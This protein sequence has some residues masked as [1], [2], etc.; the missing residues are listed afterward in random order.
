MPSKTQT[1]LL[2]KI[3]NEHVPIDHLL[4]SFDVKWH[5]M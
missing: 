3:K 4:A 2:K 1:I 5:L